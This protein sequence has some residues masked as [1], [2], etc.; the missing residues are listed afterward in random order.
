MLPSVTLV[1][2]VRKG[3]SSAADTLKHFCMLAVSNEWILCYTDSDK[4][5]ACRDDSVTG[6]REFE[7]GGRIT[8]VSATVEQNIFLFL[9]DNG[10]C[11]KVKCSDSQVE[12]SP[13]LECQKVPSRTFVFEDGQCAI[14]LG[15]QPS[16]LLCK[17]WSMHLRQIL[18][19][20]DALSYTSGMVKAH[21]DGT[22]SFCATTPVDESQG[23]PC[24]QKSSCVPNFPVHLRLLPAQ[25]IAALKL[26]QHNG[27]VV[28]LIAV[29]TSGS[30]AVSVGG[31]PGQGSHTCKQQLLIIAAWSSLDKRMLQGK[32]P[33]R[34]Q[35]KPR[36]FSKG[37]GEL[38]ALQCIA[39]QEFNSTGY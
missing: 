21:R 36:V 22:L 23:V 30:I 7:I 2:T 31:E 27:T 9:L 16:I 35:Y 17:K 19:D 13:A 6:F 15:D 28:G 25:P 11:K 33:C 37:Q 8:H 38:M 32:E 12:I 3:S 4:W 26:L 39:W 5:V 14:S 18:L 34:A 29:G 20:V 24:Y 10:D 1:A